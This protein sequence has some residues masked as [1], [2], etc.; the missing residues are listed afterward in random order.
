M[1]SLLSCDGAENTRNISSLFRHFCLA[2]R[3]KSFFYGVYVSFE[4]DIFRLDRIKNLGNTLCIT[5]IFCEVW[6]EKIRFKPTCLYL[7]SAYDRKPYDIL[8]GLIL[9]CDMCLFFRQGSH[10]A[11]QTGKTGRFGK[12]IFA[13][14]I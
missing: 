12:R 3:T 4:G 5:G 7:K 1:K 2:I 11:A 6:A 14:S 8:R 10:D 9:L 13:A